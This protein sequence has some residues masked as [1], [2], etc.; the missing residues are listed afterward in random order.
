MKVLLINNTFGNFGG[1]SEKVTYDTG[2]ILREKGIEVFFFS[3]NK[4]PYYE[5]NYEY[6]HFFPKDFKKFQ[7]INP[8]KIFY[9]FEAEKNLSN[10]IKIIKPDIVHINCI[11]HN[12]TASVLSSCKKNKTPVV[13][14]FHDSHFACPAATLTKGENGYCKNMECINGNIFSCIK[15]KCFNNNL[16]KSSIAGF[17]FLFRKTMNYYEIQ[18]A[19]IC[20][21]NYLYNIAVKSGIKK[22]KLFVAANFVNREYFDIQ[23]SYSSQNYFLYVGR[24]V[25]EKGLD[26]LLWAFKDLPEIKLKI[27]GDGNYKSNL[28]NLSKDLN[29]SNV[30]FLGFKKGIELENEYKNATA[31]LL[32]SICSEN[33][34]LTL[35][36]SFAWGKPVI[37]SNIGG[38][39]EIAI[40]DY[41]GFVVPPCNSTEITQAVHKLHDNK[42]LA[43]SMGINA[44]KTLEEKYN[45]EVYF[46]KLKNI[47]KSVLS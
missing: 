24:L 11:Q 19:F 44:R 40:N 4:K 7:M 38:I 17:E 9:N 15:N 6:S 26:Y 10:F 29:L 20:P 5:E 34:P 45:S 16:L 27:V 2:K 8:L 35:L 18:D 46:N 30:E 13:M 43:L 37:A 25:K 39:P 32:C 21:S 1:G 47:Y 12:L 3:S 33:S 42:K 22:D 23:P 28:E 41:N 14:T 36:E 31:V